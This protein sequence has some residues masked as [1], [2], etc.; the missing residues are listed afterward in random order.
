MMIRNRI[1]STMIG[2]ALNTYN[3]LAVVVLNIL[4]WRNHLWNEK[5]WT[6]MRQKNRTS[7]ESAESFEL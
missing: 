5:K 6:K 1:R 4:M 3:A 2:L 7:E